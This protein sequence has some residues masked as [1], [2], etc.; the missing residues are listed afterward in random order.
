MCSSN[1]GETIGA[2]TLAMH[3][4]KLPIPTKLRPELPEAVDAWFARACAK[5]PSDR[6]QSAK[7]L[8]AALRAAL[9]ERAPMSSRIDPAELG[10]ESSMN[11][12]LVS[13]GLTANAPPSRR[14]A[15]FA[16][17]A[18]MSERDVVAPSTAL[19]AGGGAASKRTASTDD[20][21]I[22][23][24]PFASRRPQM[25]G[26][27]ALGLLLAVVGYFATR[28]A[29]KPSHA[30]GGEP[31]SSIAPV[32]AGHDGPPIV[33]ATDAQSAAKAPPQ[34]SAPPVVAGGAVAAPPVTAV[35]ATPADRA[36][37]RSP[38]SRPTKPTRKSND[39]DIK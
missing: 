34:E 29:V 31:A 19:G 23:D 1:L 3:A 35:R 22:V 12:G 17:A 18:T 15:A 39:D 6:F 25:A 26:L 13:A 2:V 27:A 33:A 4:G 11:A 28:G 32:A 16:H 9:G 5:D 24:V 8:S 21:A 7:E 10:T 37:A 14:D 30:G 38:I 36:G 20:G